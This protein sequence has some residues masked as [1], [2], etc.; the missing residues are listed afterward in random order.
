MGALSPKYV[1]SVALINSER[2]A[3]KLRVTFQNE[4]VHY[5]TCN[6][7]GCKI[8]NL[9][10]EGTFKSVNP[11]QEM[12]FLVPELGFAQGVDTRDVT[13]VSEEFFQ[14]KSKIGV[15]SEVVQEVFK[16]AKKSSLSFE[17]ELR[18]MGNVPVVSIRD[19]NYFDNDN[20]FL[21]LKRIKLKKSS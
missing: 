19:M 16:R 3:I 1:K 17:D 21:I 10:D 6:L 13:K 11:I 14:L 20:E 2:L 18:E 4:E 8:I 15:D 5:Y 12:V 7:P 9:V